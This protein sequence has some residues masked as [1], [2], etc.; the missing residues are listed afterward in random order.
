MMSIPKGKKSQSD[1]DLVKRKLNEEKMEK[2]QQMKFDMAEKQLVGKMSFVGYL[3]K[4][5]QTLHL[6]FDRILSVF[7]DA[8]FI[9]QHNPP[10]THQDNIS[11]ATP[12]LNTSFLQLIQGVKKASGTPLSTL[13]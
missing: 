1:I 6:A 12:H 9:L 2:R 11:I 3:K 7:N 5:P 13:S 4:K 10:K 8:C